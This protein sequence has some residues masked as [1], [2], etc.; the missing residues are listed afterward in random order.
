MRR[1]MFFRIV[2]VGVFANIYLANTNLAIANGPP[3]QCVGDVDY[4]KAPCFASHAYMTGDEYEGVYRNGKFN[5]EGKLTKSDGS[6]Y[7]GT[8][9]EGELNG[10]G[11][12]LTS[13]G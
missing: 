1:I 8:F 2:L 10:N 5:G 7:E 12:L 3:P 4:S 13:T 9:V 6:V 11:S